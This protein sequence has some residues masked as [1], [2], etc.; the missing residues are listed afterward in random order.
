M[1]PPGPG[2]QTGRMEPARVS[3]PRA[4]LIGAAA[5][6]VT[7]GTAG[8]VAA[9]LAP[10]AAPLPALGAAF[11]DL[12]PAWLK[13]A[14]IAAFGTRDKAALTVG[15]VVVVVGLAALAGLVAVRSR[16]AGVALVVGLGTVTALAATSRAGAGPAAAVPA[17]VGTAA[18]AATLWLLAGHRGARPPD[19]GDGTDRRTFLLLSGAALGLGVLATLGGQ[20]LGATRQA[21][22]VARAALRI[23]RAAVPAP[24]LPDGVQVPGL[25]PFVTPAAEFYRIDTAFT[26]P[27][28]DPATWSLRVHG[29]VEREVE[30]DLAELLDGE[31]REAWIT[32][33]CVSNP[34]GGS[35]A[36]NALWTGVPVRDL[37]ARAGPRPEAD[38]VLSTSVDGFTASTPIEV[39]T[40]DR[41][42]L[43]AVAM[44][45]EPL[46]LDHGFPVRLVVPGLYGY[47]SATKWLVGL[48]VTRFADATAY[49]TTRGWSER[50]PVKTA[51]RID[52]PRNGAGLA[53][54][55]VLVG[56]TAWAQHRGVEHVQ[57]QV[58]DGPWL[59]ADL[60]AVP[61]LDTWRQWSLWWDA[62]PGRH[63]LRVRAAD[64]DGVQTSDVAGAAPDGAT[65]WHSVSV[66]VRA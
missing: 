3:A 65:G 60:A 18:G 27:R 12:T 51:S 26:V 23:P 35:L 29:L 16:W 24:P 14:A 20:V 28:V 36:G 8:L 11:I 43:L 5:G 13:E 64:P 22:E 62:E 6:A 37:L 57:V 25:G 40:D 52:V 66:T 48:E 55:R 17:L 58:D 54:G 61:G 63:R 4:A 15:M 2:T 42:A 56:G 10:T 30:V 7:L 59:D 41:D 46:P 49:W 50:A 32:L 45:G 33:T 34:V 31:L 19:P 39:L 21:V 47:V 44:N 38:M 53:P 1:A 9:V